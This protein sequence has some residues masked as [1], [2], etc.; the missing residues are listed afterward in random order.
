VGISLRPKLS[1]Y[2]RD[3]AR[4]AVPALGTL[5]A[6]PLYVLADT[7]IVGRLGTTELAGLALATTVLLSVHTL[8][9]FLT[10]GTTA[11]VARLIG[12]ER[13]SDAAFQSAQGLWLA[14]ALGTFFAGLLT[15][16]GDWF[17]ELLGGE[18]DA[19]IAARRYLYISL[20]GLPFLLLNLAGAGAFTGRQDTR[21]PLLVAIAGA[22]TNLVIELILVPGLGYGVG[23][24]ALSTVIAQ[25]GTGLVFAVVV[26]R[27]ARR[28]GVSL[29]PDLSA[30][31]KLMVAGR[32]LIL[33]AVALRGSFTLGTAIAARVGVAE[34]AA[35]QVAMQI[36]GTLALALD[37]VAIAGQALTG[38]WLGAGIAD[39]AKG[40]ARRMIQIDVGLGVV[41]AIAILAV[42]EPLAALFSNDPEVVAATAFVLV[43]V[44]VSEPLNGYVFALDGILIGAGDMSYLGRTMAGAAVIF[45]G[46]GAWLITSDKGLGWLWALI[47]FFMLLRAVTLWWRWRSDRWVVLGS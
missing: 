21:T 3:I 47:S 38:R 26:I 29:R 13:E 42:R 31:T 37:A 12:A 7:A 15:V 41:S 44:A 30:I 1:P 2:D 23:A 25:V 24:S 40:A 14:M 34:L 32:A 10:Y 20:I 33:R 5:V 35:H 43:W 18:G 36:W 8:T 19:L 6:E 9:L 16:T 17:L 45:A 39:K 4:L 28:I 27:W 11:T 46:L 22:V